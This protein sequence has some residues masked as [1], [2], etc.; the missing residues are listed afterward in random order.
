MSLTITL[1]QLTF[2]SQQTRSYNN[3]KTLSERLYYTRG[4]HEAILPIYK[5]YKCEPY[6]ATCIFH[7]MNVKHACL[8]I[9][10]TS[11]HISLL[12]SAS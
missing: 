9:N 5:M 12:L 11:I 4:E 1:N 3:Y 7:I 8:C 2:N 10:S 6:I